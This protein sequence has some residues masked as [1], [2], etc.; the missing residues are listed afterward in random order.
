[1]KSDKH[2]FF[3]FYMRHGYP[4]V[5]GDMAVS[6]SLDLF[7]MVRAT[8]FANSLLTSKD[9]GLV[10]FGVGLCTHSV[11]RIAFSLS[12][13]IKIPETSGSTGSYRSKESTLFN[14]NPN[15]PPI[16]MFLHLR[17]LTC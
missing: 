5:T 16:L 13:E 9:P 1:M 17:C 7:Q 14:L 11:M 2:F 12:I 4:A 6:D 10:S 3:F 15:V 8:D